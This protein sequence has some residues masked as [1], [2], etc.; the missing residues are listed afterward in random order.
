MQRVADGKFSAS[1]RGFPL[2]LYTGGCLHDLSERDLWFAL[3]GE[4]HQDP[5]RFISEAE[6][7]KEFVGLFGPLRGDER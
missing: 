3:L 6:V 1:V 5:V 2:V 4:L 7:L